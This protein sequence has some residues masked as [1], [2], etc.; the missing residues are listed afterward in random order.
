MLPTSLQR[1]TRLLALRRL[2]GSHTYDILAKA[3]DEVYTEYEIADK[4][5]Y[6]TTDNGSNFVKCFK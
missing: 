5:S 1:S 2:E 3:M 6:Y 4:L